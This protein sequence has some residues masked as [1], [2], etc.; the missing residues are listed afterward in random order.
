MYKRQ[1]HDITDPQTGELLHS[2]DIMLRED[3]A[4]KFLAHGID[5]V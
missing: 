1:V 5:K 3:D 2:K 4:K